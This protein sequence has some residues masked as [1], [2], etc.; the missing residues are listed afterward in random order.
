[1]PDRSPALLSLREAAEELNLSE[2]Q[3]R[4]LIRAGDLPTV[5]VNPT[6]AGGSYS[7]IRIAATD[8][9]AFIDSRRTFRGDAD[10]AAS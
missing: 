2:S 1:M 7:L 4:R 6:G 8:I 9:A 5:P 3:V 10:L